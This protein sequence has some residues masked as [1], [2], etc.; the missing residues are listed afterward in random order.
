MFEF[1][2]KYQGR[3]GRNPFWKGTTIFLTSIKIKIAIQAKWSKMIAIKPVRVV[4]NVSQCS[5][6]LILKK[7]IFTNLIIKNIFFNSLI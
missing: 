7:S 3:Q 1:I 2:M 6:Y 4:K 5:Y